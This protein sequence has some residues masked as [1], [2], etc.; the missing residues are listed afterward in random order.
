M[1]DW[2]AAYIAGI[3]DGEGSIL[4]TRMHKNEYRRPCI[5]IASTDQEL[6]IYIQTLTGGSITN[7]KNYNSD[8]HKDSYILSIKNKENVLFILDR[9][10]SFL[11]IE[12]KRSRAQWILENYNLVTPR[13]GKY[14]TELKKKKITFEENF[15]RI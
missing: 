3:I 4:L 13:N 15:F 2:E 9:V 14:N 12:K 10:I 8:R 5:T 1:D 7:K 11:R 6:L